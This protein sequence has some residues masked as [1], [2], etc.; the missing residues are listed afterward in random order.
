LLG[1][2]IRHLIIFKQ[3]L[4][5]CCLLPGATGYEGFVFDGEPGN[6]GVPGWPI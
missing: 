2:L 6:P 4:F 5:S 1:K 3:K